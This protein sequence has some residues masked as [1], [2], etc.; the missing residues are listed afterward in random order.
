MSSWKIPG[1]LA[2]PK[3]HDLPLEDSAIWNDK[4]RQL[5]R[6]HCELDLPEAGSHI[7]LRLELATSQCF[8]CGFKVRQ[9]A[10]M[11]DRP[12]VDFPVV[13]HHAT[14]LADFFRFIFVF[15]HQKC[16]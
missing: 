9:I 3:A 7:E 12:L 11:R 14:R 10:G 15:F 4:C 1:A 6:S 16:W 2:K 5:P 8:D 13:T